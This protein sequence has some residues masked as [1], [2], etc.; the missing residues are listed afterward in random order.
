MIR[1]TKLDRVIRVRIEHELYNALTL[2]A[3]AN[4]CSL[5]EAIR[6]LMKGG[7]ILYHPNVKIQLLKV[8]KEVLHATDDD[9]YVDIAKLNAR[10]TPEA[11]R[12]IE[13]LEKTIRS[14]R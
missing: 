4:K 11:V 5:S 3:E 1:R 6:F 7:Y 12:E 14:S 13:K 10:L 2:I 9:M 8:L